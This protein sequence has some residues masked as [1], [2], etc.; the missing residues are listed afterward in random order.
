MGINPQRDEP[1]TAREEPLRLGRIERERANG[2]TASL[3]SRAHGFDRRQHVRM[4]GL[5]Q[6]VHAAG[7]IVWPD[8]NAIHARNRQN[9]LNLPDAFDML[10]LEK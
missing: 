6:K 7:E 3:A 10:D 5:A 4:G 8:Q 2:H 1:K 9:L